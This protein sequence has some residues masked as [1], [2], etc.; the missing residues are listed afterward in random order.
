MRQIHPDTRFLLLG[1]P[2]SCAASVR[3]G[4]QAAG[5]SVDLVRHGPRAHRLVRAK[6]YDVILV[7]LPGRPVTSLADLAFYRQHGT[8][9]RLLAVVP[10]RNV[11]DIVRVLDSG[12]D[13]CVTMPFDVDELLARLCALAR[14]AGDRWPKGTVIR[15]HDLEIDTGTRTVRRDGRVLPLTVREYALLQL[16][17]MHRGQVVTR[18]RI[19]EKLFGGADEMTSNA[20]DVYIRYLRAKVDRGFNRPLILTRWGQGYLLRDENYPDV[21]AG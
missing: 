18:H 2:K 7:T 15:T 9:A 1:L 4:L 21:S 17:A 6:G 16:L 19:W 12:A 11:G 3:L 10:A 14:R 20:I 8:G 13:D 5:A